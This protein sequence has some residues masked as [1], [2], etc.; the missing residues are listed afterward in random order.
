MIEKYFG[1]RD[2][3]L[4]ADLVS[5][6]IISE[7]NAA[8]YYPAYA[9]NHPLFTE[10]MHIYSDTKVSDFLV[11]VTDDQR[12]GLVNEWNEARGSCRFLTFLQAVPDP[13]NISHNS[14]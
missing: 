11:S 1:T 12:I 14:H 3:G 6:S 13:R 8:Q 4:V 5:Y 9:Y 7:N 2:G 10:K